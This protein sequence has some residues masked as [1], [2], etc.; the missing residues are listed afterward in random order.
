MT[1]LFALIPCPVALAVA[2]LFMRNPRMLTRIAAWGMVGQFAIALRFWAP[3][4]RGHGTPT[5]REVTAGFCVDSM[6]AFFVLLTT[7]VVTC[8]LIHAVGYFA[9][10]AK[11]PHPPS[12]RHLAQFYFVIPL[13][14]LAM[15]SV[16]TADNL[17]YLWIGMEA[18]TL[19]SAPL[20]YF[21]RSRHALEATWKY[22]IVC[23]VGIAFAFFGTAMLFTA[24]QQAGTLGDGSLSLT[25][26]SIHARQLPA[27]LVRVGYMFIL[28]G[29]GTKAGFFPLHSW[30]PDAHSE[31]PAPAS[32]R[33]R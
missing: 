30:L 25:Q 16:I 15:Y 20:V 32:G 3:R 2:A 10:D 4:L 12:P 8:A 19:L 1:P 14:L 33:P 9:R 7:L 26:L 29:Y 11:G 24:S 5:A 31:A 18:T 17:G 23:S 28:L 13:F 27:G 6:A 21:R 22:V